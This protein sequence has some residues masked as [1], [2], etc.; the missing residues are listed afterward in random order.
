MDGCSPCKKIGVAIDVLVAGIRAFAV[1]RKVSFDTHFEMLWLSDHSAFLLAS[2]CLDTTIVP[3]SVENVA[4]RMSLLRF[5]ISVF[6][7][8]TSA[9]SVSYKG[10]TGG[11]NAVSCSP[12]TT[13]DGKLQ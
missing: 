2:V 1:K 10:H 3:Y 5:S 4:L 13:S 12:V 6:N 7:A 9:S 8:D 11:V